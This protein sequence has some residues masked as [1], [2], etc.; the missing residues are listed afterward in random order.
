M[1]KLWKAT[2]G[3]ETHEE[4]FMHRYEH[5]RQQALK[6]AG[7]DRQHG[8]ARH[9]TDCLRMPRR[10]PKRYIDDPNSLSF[11]T[12]AVPEFPSTSLGQSSFDVLSGLRSA[13][14]SNAH[15]E[16]YREA[17]LQEIYEDKESA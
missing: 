12:G 3:G 17:E 2:P 11:M 4:L 9:V 15:A 16:C 6:L 13:V 10:E 1:L 5:L 7:N 8:H 14:F